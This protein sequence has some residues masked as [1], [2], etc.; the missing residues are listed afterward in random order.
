[1]NENPSVRIESAGSKTCNNRPPKKRKYCFEL[2]D[3]MLVVKSSAFTRAIM[4]SKQY[5][6]VLVCVTS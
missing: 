2:L 4:H 1:M 6:G 5:C 3:C